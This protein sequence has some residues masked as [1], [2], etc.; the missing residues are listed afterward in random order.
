MRAFFLYH[1]L[2]VLSDINCYMVFQYFKSFWVKIQTLINFIRQS[3]P[4]VF[5][6]DLLQLFFT[7]LMQN[8]HGLNAF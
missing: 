6:E 3:F 1:G 7:Q 2:I 4:T 8:L 5:A